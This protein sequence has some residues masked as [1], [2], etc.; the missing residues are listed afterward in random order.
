M[1]L[2]LNLDKIFNKYGIYKLTSSVIHERKTNIWGSINKCVTLRDS[3]YMIKYW[4][5]IN[6][7]EFIFIMLSYL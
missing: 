2:Y 6:W 3:S 5:I 1:H 7:I 4:K